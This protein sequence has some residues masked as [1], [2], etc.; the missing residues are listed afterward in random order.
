MTLIVLICANRHRWWGGAMGKFAAGDRC[1][2]TGC[3]HLLVVDNDSPHNK[4]AEER[5]METIL[6]RLAP[7]GMCGYPL[8]HRDK[9]LCSCTCALGKGHKGRHRCELV[10]VTERDSAPPRDDDREPSKSVHN[11][12]RRPS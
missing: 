6:D 10:A 7:R 1:P 8:G 3:P 11:G 2:T 5:R 4:L 9:H 12:G